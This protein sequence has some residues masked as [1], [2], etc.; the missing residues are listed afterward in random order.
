M[1]C[2]SCG[3]SRVY[4]SRTR[5]RTEKLAHAILPIHYFRCHACNWRRMRFQRRVMNILIVT[6]LGLVSGYLLFELASPIIRV[7][8]HLVLS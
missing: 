7:M 8:L 2:P 4:K 3:S 1:K 6:L 5:T